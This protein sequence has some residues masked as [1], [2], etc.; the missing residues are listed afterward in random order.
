MQD[1]FDQGAKM[2]AKKVAAL[3]PEVACFVGLL[4]ATAYLGRQ[5]R[6]GPINE[7]IG[8]TRL[9]A[10]P[11]PS[12]R[13]AH[14]GK[15][16]ILQFFKDLAHFVGGPRNAEPDLLLPSNRSPSYNNGC[17]FNLNVEEIMNEIIFFVVEEAFPLRGFI[18]SWLSVLP[19]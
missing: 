12:R 1:E 18:A 10:I 16:G 7:T 8:Q 19:S 14:Y 6:P 3:Q 5:I 17:K 11:S 9:F 4:G 15:E 2:L 13:N